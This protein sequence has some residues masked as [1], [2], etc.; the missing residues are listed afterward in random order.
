MDQG[1]QNGGIGHSSP[2]PIAN[3][4]SAPMFQIAD[5]GIVAIEH[6]MMIRNI[7]EGLKTMAKSVSLQQVCNVGIICYFYLFNCITVYIA[8]LPWQHLSIPI[9]YSLCEQYQK[10]VH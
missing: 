5:R 6:P 7:D 10:I 8:S 9:G 3:S 4:H 2:L 1:I